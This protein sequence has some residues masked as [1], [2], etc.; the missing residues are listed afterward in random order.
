MSSSLCRSLNHPILLEIER[1]R[2]ATRISSRSPQIVPTLRNPRGLRWLLRYRFDH[3]RPPAGVKW[4]RV[5][6]FWGWWKGDKRETT[7]RRDTDKYGI[8]YDTV[9]K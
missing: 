8:R 6:R 4:G 7:E 3:G 2:F 9:K 1:A 5:V